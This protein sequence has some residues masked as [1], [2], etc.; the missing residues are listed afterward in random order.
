[1]TT[2]S[3]SATAK[4][5]TAKPT[6]AKAPATAKKPQ[7]H[8]PPTPKRE[9]V[10]DGTNVTIGE[11][12]YYVADE[13]LNDFEL[14]DTMAEA[15]RNRDLSLFP[16]IYRG[17][18]GKDGYRAALDNIRGDNGRV[19]VEAASALLDSILRTLNPNG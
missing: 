17:L 4:A 18:L 10:K 1:M 8:K 5:P 11:H 16:T 6:T 3:K 12:T 2:T 13:N 19:S 14:V 7:D 15:E 9:R